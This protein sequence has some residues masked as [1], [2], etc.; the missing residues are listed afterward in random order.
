MTILDKYKK[1]Y[2]S[3]EK[4]EMTI[5]E[6]LEKAKKD[7]ALYASAHRRLLNAIGEP[8][9]VETSQH[10]RLSRIFGNRVVRIY[11]KFS[12]FYGLET[13]IEQFVAVLRH[14]AQGLEEKNQLIALLGPVGSAKSSF[15][16]RIKE[17]MEESPIYVLKGSPCF[18][19]PLGLFDVSDAKGLGL[20]AYALQRRASKWAYKRLKEYKG[21]ISQ[22]KVVK[23]FPSQMY[24][25]GICK[26]EAGDPN[27]QDISVLTGKLDI[28]KI[29]HFSQDDPDA[30]SYSGGL[31][32]STQGL[33]EFV[34]ML[35]ADPKVLHPL[36]TALQEHHYTGTESIGPMPFDGIVLAH[37]NEEQWDKFQSNS[38]NQAFLDRFCVVKVPYNLRRDEEVKIFEKLI[39]HSELVKAP[40]A[41]HTYDCLASFT[42]LTKLSDPENSN[43]YS[44]LH[45]YNGEDVRNKD[46][47]AKSIDEYQRDAAKTEGFFGVS[48]RTAYKL[49]AETFN[50]DPKEIAADPVHLFVVIRNYMKREKLS[51]TK[52]D[53]YEAYLEFVEQEFYKKLGKDIQS[54]FIEQRQEYL[55]NA[56][57]HYIARADSW[58]QDKDYKDPDTGLLMSREELDDLLSEIEKPAGL[59][60]PKDFRHELINWVLRYQAAKK[61]M[62]AWNAYAP[63]RRVLEKAL[64]DK[65]DDLIP[66]LSARG[67][68]SS[69][70]KTQYKSFVD[71]MKE[72]GYTDRQVQRLVDAYV[73]YKKA[74]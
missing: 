40:C 59:A 14:A 71:N 55:Q 12:D 29:E 63:I 13:S 48:T 47:K 49:L 53:T 54:S 45:V 46:T 37:F 6:Y 72:L 42:V 50:Y 57:E 66:V 39:D 74:E 17:L 18:E 25:I 56:F 36:L 38:D 5:G 2:S 33:L 21:D 67:T 51:E 20:P 68:K 16:E 35:R 30:Y 19:N 69:S 3:L 22:F 10:P 11:K 31:C 61:K 60:N 70:A 7:P 23:I 4:E 52:T 41:P 27:T 1:K 64:F 44:K 62:P 24:E 8:E 65:M 34:E 26:V 43:I 58:T 9:L 32:K 73:K 28:R 15:A